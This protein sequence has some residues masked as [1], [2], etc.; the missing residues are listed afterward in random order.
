[1]AVWKQLRGVLPKDSQVFI[2]K[3]NQLP[4]MQGRYFTP[5]DENMVLI[6]LTNA[7]FDVSELTISALDGSSSDFPGGS[8]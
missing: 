4:Q 6:S 1:M 8:F 2:S 5:T 3:P 7:T